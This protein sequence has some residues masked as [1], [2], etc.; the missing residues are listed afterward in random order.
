MFHLVNW[1]CTERKNEI[2]I[3]FLMRAFN[4]S[5]SLVRSAL[6]NGS[7]PPK[8]RGRHLAVGPESDSNILAWMKNQAEKTAAEARIDIKNYCREVWKCE[9]SRGWVYSLI[10]PHSVELTEKKSKV[11]HKKSR[12]CKFH[13][14]SWKK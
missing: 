9:A 14:S 5:R 6:A 1:A 13:E 4:C 8:L 7:S 12:V 3:G 11:H 10:S 2:S